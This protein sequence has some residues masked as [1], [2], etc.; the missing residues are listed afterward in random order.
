MHLQEE[1]V[2]RKKDIAEI[3]N[4]ERITETSAKKTQRIK[5]CFILGKNNRSNY[6]KYQNAKRKPKNMNAHIL[7]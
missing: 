7:F 3:K 5:F 6:A 4:Q 1:N 2:M